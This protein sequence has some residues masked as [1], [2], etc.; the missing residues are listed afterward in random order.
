ML[1][2]G[3]RLVVTW[4]PCLHKVKHRAQAQHFREAHHEQQITGRSLYS[5]R[6]GTA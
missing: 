6:L 2:S 5:R 3:L 4:E 1:K